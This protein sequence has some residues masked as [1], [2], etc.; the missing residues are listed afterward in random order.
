MIIEK[1]GT[2]KTVEEAKENALVEMG[3]S[4]ESDI[5]YDF[6][7][8]DLPQ[9]KVLG[10]FGGSLAKVRVFR[11]VADPVVD[12]KVEAAEEK[13]SASKKK[14]AQAVKAVRVNAKAQKAQ[15]SEKKAREI[16]DE[17][18]AETVT[19]LETVL[20]NM[21]VEEFTTEPVKQDDGIMINISGQKLGT[22][23]GR[24]GETIDALQHLVSLVAN[25]GK[26]EYLRVTLNP[27]EYREKRESVLIG[28]AQKSA[29]K[30]LRL[31]K[32]TV[33]EPM[34]SYERRIIHNA[35]QAIDGVDSWS[36]GEGDHRRVVIGNKEF[37]SERRGN[38]DRR[39]SRG[40]NRGRNGRD[41]M[42]RSDNRVKTEIT[43]EPI[44]DS[45]GPLYGVIKAEDKSSAE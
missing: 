16:S 37:A 20:K 25:K 41:R 15:K 9:K 12:K 10:L 28:V 38:Y 11:E 44:K 42:S 43:R 5:E 8:V 18:I 33:L 2:G 29:E 22:A 34:N 13:P 39:G 1:F 19:Y 14:A 17:Q 32:N 45:S 40:G 23:I 31:K 27:G 21:G 30:A 3:I 26:N 36:V 6:E 4:A 7:I 24:K 35:V